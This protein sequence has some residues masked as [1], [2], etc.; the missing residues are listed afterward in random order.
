MMMNLAVLLG[1]VTAGWAGTETVLYQFTGNDGSTP[2]AG[3]TFD[4]AGN[5][6]GTTT[7]GGTGT[8]RTTCGT[9]FKLSPV[10]RGWKE[11]VL[12]DFSG[13]GD[14]ADP[15]SGL[16][17][18]QAGD[19]Y[20]TTTYG[21]GT[22]CNG[23]G[24]GTVFKLVRT[25]GSSWTETILYAFG[26]G[27]DGSNPLAGLVMDGAGNLYGTTLAGGVNGRGTVFELAYTSGVGWKETLIHSFGGGS[28]DG[29]GPFAGLIFDKNGSLYGTTYHGGV[30]G[31]GCVFALTRMGKGWEFTL[32]HSFLNNGKDGYYPAGS[33]I[34]DSDGSL[35]STTRSGGTKGYGTVFQLQPF[36]R[37]WRERI[38]HSFVG[39][40]DGSEP[41]AGLVVDKAHNLYGTAAYGGSGSGTVFR[42][43]REKSGWVLTLLHAFAGGTSDGGRPLAPLI[44]DTAGN[45]YGTTALY[46]GGCFGNGC[47][48]VF[49]VA[50]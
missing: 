26:G 2:Q 19:I 18:D 7:D 33:L 37:H 46:G 20:G 8:C 34:F 28:S 16:I 45:L 12:H 21:G 43:N 49:E 24:C 10:S 48:I 4:A 29:S 47:G 36:G 25:S 38:T 5:L 27:T 14:G 3:L 17:F 1:S 40:N 32:L 50:P 44:L 15:Q 22:G 13:G 42:L 6:Y 30:Y 41:S 9:V 31:L 23:N 35:H 11:T 39:T